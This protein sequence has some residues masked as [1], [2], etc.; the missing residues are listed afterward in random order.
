MR[1][2]RKESRVT[3]FQLVWLSRGST[4]QDW[5]HSQKDQLSSSGWET[6]ECKVTGI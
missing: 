4:Q 3:G 1:A 5:Q 2:E 6:A